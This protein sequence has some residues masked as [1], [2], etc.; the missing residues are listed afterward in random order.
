MDCDRALKFDFVIQKRRDVDSGFSPGER[1]G[2]RFIHDAFPCSGVIV[3]RMSCSSINIARYPCYNPLVIVIGIIDRL[4]NWWWCDSLS[5]KL[6]LEDEAFCFGE[7][8]SYSLHSS[9]LLCSSII[10]S[11][12]IR[13]FLLGYTSNSDW[14]GSGTKLRLVSCIIVKQVPQGV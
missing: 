10:L 7:L 2:R 12:A 5:P 11:D 6:L 1:R 13:L 14:I 9:S 4:L 8:L 3:L